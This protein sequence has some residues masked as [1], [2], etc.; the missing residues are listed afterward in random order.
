MGRGFGGIAGVVKA[1]VF[2]F[3]PFAEIIEATPV[4]FV[5]GFNPVKPTS[6]ESE[7]SEPLYVLAL[8]EEDL[9]FTEYPHPLREFRVIE[10]EVVEFFQLGFLF[11]VLT[12]LRLGATLLIE[13]LYFL[14]SSQFASNV[15]VTIVPLVVAVI[16][17]GPFLKHDVFTTRS[18]SHDLPV[19]MPVIHNPIL[20]LPA[21]S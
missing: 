4:Y 11:V 17:C 9:I 6:V 10:P 15:L 5:F 1:K 8:V 2:F 21:K 18:E 13:T 12:E 7:S 19:V 3:V 16:T 14:D 20:P